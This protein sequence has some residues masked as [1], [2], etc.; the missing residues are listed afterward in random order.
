M[1]IKLGVVG[2]YFGVAQH[3]VFILFITRI[4]KLIT[5]SSC[6]MYSHNGANVSIIAVIIFV[7]DHKLNPNLPVLVK[8]VR[9]ES[10]E[11]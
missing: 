8:Q 1:P 9:N 10:M 4:Y 5:V 11:L 7:Y 6:N 3:Y 2:R